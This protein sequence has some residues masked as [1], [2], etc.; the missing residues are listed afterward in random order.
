MT[1]ATVCR[2]RTLMVIKPDAIR[3]GLESSILKELEGY[4]AANSLRISGT[5]GVTL[6]ES[7]L[8]R[9]FMG[10]GYEFVL[11]VGMKGAKAM[12]SA[13]MSCNDEPYVLG[14]RMLTNQ[15]RGLEGLDA[16]VVVVD[17][18]D[19]V[20]KLAAFKGATDPRESEAGS[21]RGMFRSSATMLDAVLGGGVL[22]NR[23]HVP[24]NDE[25]AAYDF[26]TFLGPERVPDSVTL[27]RRHDH[28]AGVT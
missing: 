4:C 25:E 23:V 16:V 22:E 26:G 3:D 28:A 19:A 21:L 27:L 15:I 8:W 12:E 14:Y 10:K 9:H 17:G 11:K 6:T 24:D 18:Q 2:D 7:M 13:G 20:A 1:T 5:T